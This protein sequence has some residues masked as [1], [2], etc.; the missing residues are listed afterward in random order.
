MNRNRHHCS[1]YIVIVC[2]LSALLI[3]HDLKA[4]N[5]ED[6][7]GNWLIYNGTIHFSDDW[8]LFTEGQIRLWEPA[9]NLQEVFIRAIGQYH[10]SA[11]STAGIGYTRVKTEPFE[12]ESAK[13]TENR[14]IEQFSVKQKLSK[15]VI[16]HRFRLEQRWIKTEG[17]TDYRN[18]FR[19]RLQ[20]TTPLFRDS[21]GP[22]THF[23]NFYNELFLNFGDTE[24]NFDQNR[25]YGAYGWQ[26]TEQSNLQIGALWQ[27]KKRA[28]FFRLQIFYTKNFS[29]TGR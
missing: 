8:S 20:A 19:Y 2:T 13:S 12:D 1:F 10:L 11:N 25:L 9:S 21:I 18:R 4:D 5:S 15:S 17:D 23:L 3:P 22:Q 28:D 29:L 7:L 16:D 6:K 14:L 24:D 26:F 27:A